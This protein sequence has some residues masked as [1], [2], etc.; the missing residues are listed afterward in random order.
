MRQLSSVRTP[1]WGARESLG[2]LVHYE[3]LVRIMSNQ[4]ELRRRSSRRPR[5]C[6]LVR[7]EQTAEEEALYDKLSND[8]CQQVSRS[9]VLLMAFFMCVI[10]HYGECAALTLAL[11][12][13]KVC[14]LCLLF[15]VC[16]FI[17]Y[18]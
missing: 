14:C 1:A 2:E 9:L 6:E 4:S 10:V 17:V 13:C 16:C 8:F 15:V 11:F 3:Q 5:Q 7:Y 12:V 18:L